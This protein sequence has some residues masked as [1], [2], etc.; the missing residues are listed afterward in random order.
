MEGAKKQKNRERGWSILKEKGLEKEDLVGDV[1][2]LKFESLDDFL[3]VGGGLRCVREEEQ[4]RAWSEMGKNWKDG[5]MGSPF[6][7]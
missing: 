2:D 3:W 1:L 6:F 4:W 5:P 7:S